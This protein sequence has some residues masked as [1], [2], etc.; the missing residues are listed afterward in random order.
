MQLSD[1]ERHKIKALL[2]E[3][4][5]KSA[6][7]LS[8]MLANKIQLSIPHLYTFHLSPKVKILLQEEMKSGDLKAVVIKFHGEIEG[9]ANFI[10]TSASV[11][12]LVS[13]LT[14]ANP[15]SKDYLEFL[16]GTLSEVGNIVLNSICGSVGNKI[17]A[18]IN[19]TVPETLEGSFDDTLFYD[20]NDIRKVVLIGKTTFDIS[21]LSIEGM[22]TIQFEEESLKKIIDAI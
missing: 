9:K 8:E 2:N 19:Y 11:E 7:V 1:S 10:L 3:S 15:D 22:I 6:S 12:N 18:H 20:F 14:G 5:Q 4:V 21:E 17:K 13:Y 16:E